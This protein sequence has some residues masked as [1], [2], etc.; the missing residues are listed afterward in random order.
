MSATY[1]TS[2]QKRNRRVWKVNSSQKVLNNGENLREKM[3]KLEEN[4]MTM[5][6]KTKS[7]V[8]NLVV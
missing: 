3:D 6:Q 1:S 2:L 8:S 7:N 5:M 4:K